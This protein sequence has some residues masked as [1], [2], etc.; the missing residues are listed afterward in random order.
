MNCPPISFRVAG[1]AGLMSL[2]ALPAAGYII[3]FNAAGLPAGAN[4]FGNAAR[5]ASGG[6]GNSGALRLT[7]AVAGQSGSLVINSLTGGVPVSTFDV[8]FDVFCGDGGG[9]PAKGF[10]FCWSPNLPAWRPITISP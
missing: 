3:D 4:T 6:T 1:L 8:T 9:D 5:L 2:S 10:S 7:D